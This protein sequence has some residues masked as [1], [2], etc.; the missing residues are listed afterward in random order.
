MVTADHI[1]T[2]SFCKRK[3]RESRQS[4]RR[5]IRKMSRELVKS[6]EIPPQPCLVCGSEEDPSIHHVGH[7]RP[8]R[9]VFLCVPCH[10]RAHRAVYRTVRIPVALGQFSIRPEAGMQRRKAPAGG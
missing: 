9:F 2:V 10:V 3:R 1:R 6:G 5:Q 8:D 4:L 7:M